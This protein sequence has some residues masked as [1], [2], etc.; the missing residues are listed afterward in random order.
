M[1]E[2]TA[3]PCTRGMKSRCHR[4]GVLLSVLLLAA[5]DGPSD[6]TP[7]GAGQTGTVTPGIVVRN[8]GSATQAT[9]GTTNSNG[10]RLTTVIDPSGF[11]QPMPAYSL[12]I[13]ATWQ[14]QGSVQWSSNGCLAASPSL[15]WR[16]RSADGRVA[17]EF[18]PRWASQ[19]TSQYA[20]PIYRN[21]PTAPFNG[22]RDYLQSLASQRRPG[23]RVLD[24]RERPDLVARMQVPQLP[25]QGGLMVRMQMHGEAG[26]ILVA[27]EENGQAMRESIVAIGTVTDVTADMAMVGTQHARGLLTNGAMSLSAPDGQLDFDLLEQVRASI[28]VEPE[29]RGQLAR[30]QQEMANDDQRTQAE[31]ARINARGSQIAMQE[32][33]KRGQIM[34]DTRA[35]VATI[36]TGIWNT[37]QATTAAMH[38]RGID[39]L[40]GVQPYYDPIRGMPVEVD[41]SYRYLWRLADGSYYQTN[42]VNF[43]P[44]Q[45]LGLEGQALQMIQR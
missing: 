27:W 43:N 12:R 6:A 44:V 22:I 17:M 3:L 1:P 8:D 29:W 2:S 33:A 37:T 40:R 23:A 19:Q 10:F 38:E 21:C 13:P 41:N 31:I 11:G 34:A 24:Y 7:L 14:D 30:M 20:A 18:I 5:C 35:E 45:A 32:I 9:A 36:N 25:D 16:A 28:A 39:T 15:V 26:E 42:D 4:L